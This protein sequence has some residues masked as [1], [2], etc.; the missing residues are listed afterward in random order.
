MKILT[1]TARFCAEILN[2]HP[3]NIEEDVI[4]NFPVTF[5]VALSEDSLIQF[6]SQTVS[7]RNF[8][9]LSSCLRLGRPV[10]LFSLGSFIEILT[11]ILLH[12]SIIHFSKLSAILSKM[13]SDLIMYESDIGITKLSYSYIKLTTCRNK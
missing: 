12:P 13:N 4:F 2:W 1:R 6:T 11:D 5:E 9:I 8:L 7:L 3:T 10:G